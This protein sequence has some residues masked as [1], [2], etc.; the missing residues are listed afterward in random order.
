LQR[1]HP[2]T[3]TQSSTDGGPWERTHGLHA[4]HAPSLLPGR[5]PRQCKARLVTRA[6]CGSA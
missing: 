1:T 6:G 2:L 3:C 5:R 4:P